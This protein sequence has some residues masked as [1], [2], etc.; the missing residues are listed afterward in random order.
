MS[1]SL[2][3]SRITLISIVIANFSCSNKS[4]KSETEK[5]FPAKV[6]LADDDSGAPAV[7]GLDVLDD[8]NK[9]ASTKTV[10][11]DFN[12]GGE[13]ID[14]PVATASGGAEAPPSSGQG[15]GEGQ[16]QGQG[17]GQ[18][19]P[20]V[21]EVVPTPDKYEGVLD[22]KHYC[23]IAEDPN[24]AAI[25]KKDFLTPEYFDVWLV[26]IKA[27]VRA[28]RIRL[29]APNQGASVSIKDDC[30]V[31][32]DKFKQ[33]IV[34]DLSPFAGDNHD[35]QL[36][37]I[38][39]ISGSLKLRGLN[40]RDNRVLDMK[41]LRN[42]TT[43]EWLELAGNQLITIP[44]LKNF[45]NNLYMKSLL[46]LGIEYQGEPFSDLRIDYGAFSSVVENLRKIRLRH[47]YVSPRE[48]RGLNNE[49]VLSGLEALQFKVG[50]ESCR[51]DNLPYTLPYP[52]Q[53]EAER[54]KSC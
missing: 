1:I 15:E 6:R 23:M 27:T 24:Y 10:D 8:T 4:S 51:K 41:F 28:I 22:F 50:D 44:Q 38:T 48:F 49:F 54:Q 2:F 43:L 17:Q 53:I 36:I 32:Y 25:Y 45:K 34:L 19:E 30:Q 12:S 26:D 14:R 40:L 20:E 39:P 35:F 11:D 21:P 18:G 37:N 33:A 47:N 42:L 5:K 3:Y 7:R 29:P 52:T 31:A 9:I 13:D 46:E 16:G